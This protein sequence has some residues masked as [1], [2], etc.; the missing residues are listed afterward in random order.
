MKRHLN[1][2]RELLSHFISSNLDLAVSCGQ[3]LLKPQMCQSYRNKVLGERI[4]LID[5]SVIAPQNVFT[6]A[7][8]FIL[9]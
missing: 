8:Y 3:S 2:H 9:F 7:S 6:I 4:R 1:I 5:V